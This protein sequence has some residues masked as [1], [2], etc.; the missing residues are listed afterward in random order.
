MDHPPHSHDLAPTD[1]WLFPKL[2]SLLK[3][4]R[5]SDAENI[6]SPVK[7]KLTDIPV[8]DFKNCFKQWPKRWEHR[9]ELEGD[10]FEK[11]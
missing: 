4:K 5:S 1:F 2:K 9:K 8:K 10:Y 6:K 11:F 7:K 3:G